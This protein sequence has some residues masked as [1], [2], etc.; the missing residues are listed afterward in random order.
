MRNA[1]SSPATATASPKRTSPAA[2][3]KRT[4]A[5]ALLSDIVRKPALKSKPAK[6][7]KQSSKKVK[8]DKVVRDSF[9]MPKADYELIDTLKRKCLGLG[10]AVKKTE[11]LRAGLAVLEGLPGDGLVEMMRSL[12]RVKTGRPPSTAKR[13]KNGKPK[14]KKQ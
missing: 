5:A 6:A 8:R 1:Q 4:S 10:V 3:G 14:G 11:L 7:K 13:K 2:R 9:T 12:D